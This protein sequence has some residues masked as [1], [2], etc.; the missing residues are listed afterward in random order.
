MM[1]KLPGFCLVIIL[2]V[3]VGAGCGNLPNAQATATPAPTQAA[4]TP[5]PQPVEETSDA[6]TIINLSIWLPPQFAPNLDMPASSLLQER[7]DEFNTL[8]PNLN[9]TYRIKA[10]TGDASLLESLLTASEAA[11]LVLPDLVLISS[12]EFFTAA[13]GQLVYPYP[14]E[15]TPEEDADWY[16]VAYNL[17][18]YQ[19]QTYFLP[20]A[21]DALVAVYNPEEFEIF[22]S[23]WGDLLLANKAISFPP[24][25]PK[26][27]TPLAFYEAE[28]HFFDENGNLTLEEESLTRVFELF[29]DLHTAGLLP[30]NIAQIDSYERAAEQFTLGQTSIAI[31]WWSSLFFNADIATNQAIAALPTSDGNPFTMVNSWG[32]SITTPDPNEQAAAAELARFLST[33]EFTGPWTEAAQLLPLRPSAVTLWTNVQNRSAA[34]ELLPVARAAPPPE[35]YSALSAPLTEALLDV[36]TGVQTPEEAAREVIDTVGK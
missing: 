13:E 22:P 28:G 29:A 24:A 26:A 3:M 1:K 2:L 15:L 4:S 23:S 14:V 32:W 6:P 11:P 8:Y 7:L 27:A 35:V 17:S 16:P 33:A 10:Q 36:L 21:A 18:L 25:D 19:E 30:P 34:D 9:V 20:I 31:T 5:T 12:A